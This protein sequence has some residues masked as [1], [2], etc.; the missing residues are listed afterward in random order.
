MLNAA[1]K[2]LLFWRNQNKVQTPQPNWRILEPFWF[3]ENHTS[4][5]LAI[6]HPQQEERLGRIVCDVCLATDAC[7]VSDIIVNENQRHRGIAT[8]LLESALQTS[9]R[10]QLVPVNIEEAGLPF[11][12]HLAQARKL[13][14]RLGL[15][16]A[17]LEFIRSYTSPPAATMLEQD[18]LTSA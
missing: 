18:R 5:A 17:E 15:N 4:F 9:G 8:K 14:I 3:G 6:L 12:F 1:L 10:S 7:Y 2:R 16:R 11:W 13:P